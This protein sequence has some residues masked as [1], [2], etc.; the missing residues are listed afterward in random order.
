MLINLQIFLMSEII[1]YIIANIRN[2]NSRDGCLSYLSNR[3]EDIHARRLSNASLYS[4]QAIVTELNPKL[5][6]VYHFPQRHLS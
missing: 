1:Y 6:L 5:A 3:M 2:R 4:W